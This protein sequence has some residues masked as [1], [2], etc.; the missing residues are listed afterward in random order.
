[1]SEI[2]VRPIQNG[3]RKGLSEFIDVPWKI[4]NAKDHPQ[5][6]PPLRIAVKNVLDTKKNPF[7]QNADIQLFIAERD[8]KPVGR[9]AAVENRAHNKFHDENIGFYGFFEA[10]DDQ[11]VAEAL[12]DAAADW[13]RAR[14]LKAMRGPFNPSSNYTS[15]LLVRGHSQHQTI[16]TTWNPKYYTDLHEKA[17]LTGVKDLVAYAIKTDLAVK[18]PPKV[19]EYAERMRHDSRSTFRDFDMK[20]FDRDCEIIFDIYNSAWEKNWGFVPMTRAEFMHTAKD[21]KAVVDPRFMFIAEIQGK[22]A[23]F[24]L[25]LPDFNYIFKRI[26]NGRL[27]PTGLFKILLGKR[28]LK[29]V[30]IIT[31]GVKPEYRGGGIFACFT[32]ESFA[33][34][35]K[36]GILGG[37]ASWILEDNEPMNKPWRD[38]GAPLYRRWRIYERPL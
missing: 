17:G 5:Y 4:Y 3:D 6:A 27:F 23:G 18:L 15:G 38:M 21:M 33:R 19:V 8:G 7:Y 14:G 31:L 10:I 26:P 1:M 30:R 28:L 16:D 35:Q 9:I 11:K 12:F 29:T 13:L 25:A 34:A 2:K 32:H 37:E 22:P 20:H 24:M 36:Y